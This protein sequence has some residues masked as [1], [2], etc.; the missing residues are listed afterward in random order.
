MGQSPRVRALVRRFSAKPSGSDPE[1]SSALEALSAEELR[2]FVGQTLA[3]LEPDARARVQ[4]ALLRASRSAA[5]F[6]PQGPSEAVVAEVE[7]FAAAARR[8]GQADPAEVDDYLRQGVKASMA[9]HH[10]AARAIFDALIEPIA[11]AEIDL[12]QDEMVDE[13]LAVDLHECEVRYAAAVYFTTPTDG[14]AEAV[15]DALEKLQALAS[16]RE[17]IADMERAVGPLPEIDAFL[18]LWIARLERERA[19]AGDWESERD[20]WL[21]EAVAR[22]E[23]LAGLERIARTSK[24]PSAVEAWC[25]AVVAAGDWRQA[26]RA[27]E[28][29]V[30][31]VESPVWRGGFLDGA[32]L[33][34]QVLGRADVTKRLEAAWTERLRSCGCFACWWPATR[35][36]RR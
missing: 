8:V 25:A 9:G 16:L 4:D 21:R 36:R 12:G 32:A 26:L 35:R 33:A 20:I 19:P 22:T 34:A 1:V 18:P 27:Y 14:R 23:G 31:L 6:G 30:E 29:A 17:P 15:F 24:V 10:E 5:G 11:E 13:V 3:T 28:E 7:R 2:S